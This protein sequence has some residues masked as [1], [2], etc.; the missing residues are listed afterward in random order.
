VVTPPDGKTIFCECDG[1]CFFEVRGTL[2]RRLE[3]GED[4][5]VVLR[6]LSDPALGYFIQFGDKEVNNG[7]WTAQVQVGSDQYPAESGQMFEV[8]AITVNTEGDGC[9]SLPTEPLPSLSADSLPCLL[10][11]DG[12]HTVTVGCKPPKDRPSKKRLLKAL[13][14]HTYWHLYSPAREEAGTHVDENQIRTELQ[15]L[16]DSGARG[17]VTYEMM[18][19]IE[20][21]P[22]IAREIGYK[23]VIAGIYWWTAGVANGQTQSTLE[24]EKNALDAN[25][26]WIDGIAVGNEGLLDTGEWNQPRYTFADLER[27]LKSLKSE[28]PDKLVTTAGGVDSYHEYRR[29]VTD[30][31]L[32]DFIFPN[33]HPWW[34]GFRDPTLAVNNVVT[35]INSEP[36]SL[37][38]DRLLVLHESWWPT[39]VELQTEDDQVTFF[40]RLLDEDIPFC[41]GETIDQPW[42][43]GPE[44]SVGSHWG[45]WKFDTASGTYS[46][47]K[48]VDLLEAN[49]R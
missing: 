23:W 43:G 45:L 38:G 7:R 35:T 6:P 41:W 21:V 48:A 13:S 25:R 49:S 27:E 34:G 28:Y 29:L 15:M 26:K 17:I 1:P 11:M 20:N 42:K 30:D 8:W 46:R 22:R 31:D 4:F 18:N 37:R 44:G 5:Y 3:P 19:G 32:T 40:Q 10:A 36:F 9:E 14:K 47:K 16:Y 24:Q 39:D 12:P 2:S 33:I